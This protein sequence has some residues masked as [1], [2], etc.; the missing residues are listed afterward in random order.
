MFIRP[1]GITYSTIYTPPATV[2]GTPASNQVRIFSGGNVVVPYTSF[3]NNLYGPLA[4][5]AIVDGPFGKLNKSPSQVVV[6]AACRI[7]GYPNNGYPT[8]PSDSATLSKYAIQSNAGSNTVLGAAKIVNNGKINVWAD[9]WITY[10]DVW[11]S[12]GLNNNFY[13][14]DS[15]WSN[16]LDWFAEGCTP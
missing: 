8:Q 14:A 1:F 3:T 4:P 9:E 11:T 16:V 7:E 5:S 12:N 10:D 15:Y 6:N 2:G 13:Q